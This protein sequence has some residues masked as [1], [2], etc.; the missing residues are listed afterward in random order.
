MSDG[1]PRTTTLI[2]TDFEQQTLFPSLNAS[3]RPTGGRAP[4][5]AGRSGRLPRLPPPCCPQCRSGRPFPRGVVPRGGRAGPPR[6]R[7]PRLDGSGPIPGRMMPPRPRMRGGGRGGPVPPHPGTVMGRRPMGPMPPQGRGPR[8][9]IR[10]EWQGGARGRGRPGGRMVVGLRGRGRG[11]PPPPPGMAM[12]PASGRGASPR[13]QSTD[14]VTTA[15][16]APSWM[17]AVLKS[18]D[19]DDDD[20]AQTVPVSSSTTVPEDKPAPPTETSTRLPPWAKPYKAKATEPSD[21]GNQVT[22]G[23]QSTPSLGSGMPKWGQK[24]NVP[25]AKE[26]NAPRS[27][28]RVGEVV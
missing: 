25:A 15:N 26:A 3:H 12:R 18:N 8:G 13:A 24:A 1:G 16:A 27:A 23:R 7:P 6:Q 21:G 28:I 5:S 10:G 4:P 20:F 9:P 22:T 11:R 2:K 14:D 19:D 17:S